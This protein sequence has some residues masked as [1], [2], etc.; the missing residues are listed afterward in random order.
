[1]LLR[2]IGNKSKIAKEIVKHFPEHSV[3]ID[4][5]FGAGGLFFNKPVVQYNFLNDIDS[6]IINLF[7]VLMKQKDELIEYLELVPYSADFFNIAKKNIPANNIEK[8]VYFLVLSNW[9]FMGGSD[10]I[11]FTAHSN[12]KKI[13]LNNITN[14]Y[15]ILINQ[16]NT[17][18]LN[19]D[20][21]EILEQISFDIDRPNQKRFSL[22][23]ADKPYSNTTNN[24][25]N[26][27][28]K[29]DDI[30]L[31]DVLLKS[32][33]KFAISEFKD[34]SFEKLAIDAGLN[35]IDIKERCTLKSR[36]TEILITNYKNEI[37]LFNR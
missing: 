5:F 20:F 1:M 18:F 33:L 3:F 25:S 2:R 6:D 15:R 32:D 17:K 8:A 24:Y 11:A 30:D 12:A 22:V 14:T 7:N 27:W 4:M 13:T 36:N 31:L 34:S 23:Y 16:Y 9:S 35:V 28:S 37:E 29:K 19:C 26:N 21:R 10:M